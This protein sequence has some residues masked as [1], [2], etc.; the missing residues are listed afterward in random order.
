MA[1]IHSTPED[2]L[3]A[4]QALV[5]RPKQP[6]SLQRKFLVGVG[7]IFLGFC[8]VFAVLIYYHEKRVLEEAAQ[9]K[10]E[11]VMAAAEAARAFVQE[12]LRPRMYE[13]FG[14]DAFVLEAMSTSYVG[15]AVMDRFKEARPE[16]Q[17]RRVARRARNPASQA[18]PLELQLIDFFA[19]HPD[20]QSWQG[21]VKINGRSNFLRAKPDRF[22]QLCLHCHGDPR[23]APPTLVALYGSER[24]FGHQVGEL[25]GVTAVSIPVDFALSQI[26]NKALSA[27]GISFFCLSILYIGINFFFNRVV[28]HNLRDLLAI[29]RHGLRDGEAPELPE[30]A[31]GGDEIQELAATARLMVDHL[32]LNREQLEKY[33]HNLELLLT[34]HTQDKELMQSVF[35]GISDMLVLLDRDLQIIM[36]NQ[37]FLK[38]FGVALEEVVNQPCSFATHGDC[39]FSPVSIEAVIRSR[40]PGMEEVHHGNGEIFLIH[41]YPI[42]NE[43][44]EVDRIVGYAKD[45]TSA[46]KAE[47]AIRHMEKLASL[48]QLAGGIAHEINNP[49]GV[50]LCYTDILKRELADFPQGLKDVGVIEKHTRACQRIVADL[51]KF[52]RSQ[53]TSRQLAA[54]N[55]AIEEVVRMVERQFTR[56]RCRIKL[57]LAP[58]LPLLFLDVD[59]MKQV[60]LNLL[61]NALQ[62]MKKDHGQVRIS[63]RLDK[64]EGEVQITFWDNGIGIPL[65]IRDKIFDPF[66]TTKKVGKGTGLGLSVS[67]GIIKDHGGDLRV[68][69]APGQW[70]RFTITLPLARQEND[71]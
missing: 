40:K 59:K 41:Y 6:F 10:A 36:V 66:F 60:Y 71:A 45:I 27:F 47:N 57:D 51:L 26:M 48:G 65:D 62:A 68:D 4:P 2:L 50:I 11:L 58:D 29:F 17:Y 24:G 46:K 44:G 61:M 30:S 20:Q 3:A 31:K 35:D 34:Q 16:Y 12:V 13:V 37:A 21:I 52:A 39:P 8:V 22:S 53:E 18:Q 42:L 64:N 28:V 19:A 38:Y 70:T 9:E 25:A 32:R 43:K 63:S 54:V 69:S 14:K 49:L 56:Q 23:D 5:E 1:D 33:A 55:P 67:Y 15:R 7:L